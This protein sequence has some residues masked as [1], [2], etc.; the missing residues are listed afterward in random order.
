[1]GYNSGKDKTRRNVNKLKKLRKTGKHK[2]T[3]KKVGGMD[4]SNIYN[5]TIGAITKIKQY[6]LDNTKTVV[7]NAFNNYKNYKSTTSLLNGDDVI[8]INSFDILIDEF[9][10]KDTLIKNIFKN[11]TDY[12]DRITKFDNSR[13][14]E[15]IV[16]FITTSLNT[17]IINYNDTVREN[18]ITIFIEFFNKIKEQ[19]PLST[20][21]SNV[22]V[23]ANRKQY[24]IQFF[25]EHLFNKLTIGSFLDSNLGAVSNINTE[26]DDTSFLKNIYIYIVY[27]LSTLLENNRFYIS[28]YFIKI[29]KA[30]L[31]EK[32]KTVYDKNSK[33]VMDIS[34]EK[35]K[36]S[37]LLVKNVLNTQ[38]YFNDINISKDDIDY[39]IKLLEKIKSSN[40]R[41]NNSVPV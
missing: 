33:T 2:R 15:S 17:Y 24:I 25:D 20:D 35:Y 9:K 4:F 32:F 10:N 40:S 14:K 41:T 16:D 30:L 27:T 12:N 13:F 21:K 18:L 31:K 3:N 8:T 5:G 36:F 22:T 39:H 11:D 37:C 7:N 29:I 6:G 26:S 34:I 38:Y 1:M 23:Q 28:K 19:S